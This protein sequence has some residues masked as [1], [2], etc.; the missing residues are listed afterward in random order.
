MYLYHIFIIH[1]SVNEHLGCFYVLAIVNIA[2]MN[3]GV[4]LSLL[5][6]AV[7][8]APRTEPATL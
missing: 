3:F 8:S 4:Q 7:Y 5:F 1:S 2:A 6:A